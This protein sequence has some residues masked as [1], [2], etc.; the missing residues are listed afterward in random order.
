MN[1]YNE[2]MQT[3]RLAME[4]GI[5][6][7]LEGFK[8]FMEFIGNPQDSYS[9]VQIG[10]PNG[11]TS[12]SRYTAAILKQCGM[13]TGLYTSP[14]L[15]F[16][17]ERMEVDGAVSSDEMFADAIIS[18][19]DKAQE[20][21]QAGIIPFC[22][23]FELLTASGF[24][25]FEQEKCDWAVLEVGL[26]GMWDATSACT[27]KVAVVTGIDLEHTHILGNTVEEIAVQKAAI[28]KPG[29]FAILGPGTEET[30]QVFL[31]R[32]AEVG[33][34]YK[35]IEP[36]YQ[37]INYIGASYQIIN[38]TTAWAA[39][40]AA[41]SREIS[42]ETVQAAVD[43]LIIPG[44]FEILRDEP[45]LMIDATHNPQAAKY[46]VDAMEA[47]FT[48]ADDEN[49]VRK[50]NELDTLL[51]CILDDKD[52]EG[53]INTLAPLFRNIAVTQSHSTRAF[54]AE[55]LFELVKLYDGRTPRLF[56]NI[57]DALAEINANGETAM[58][59][60]SITLAGEAKATYLGK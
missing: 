12:T 48:F 27:P 10:G 23:E 6:A 59:T 36:P 14:E 44:R 46:L 2:A 8:A 17:P 42:L 21:V 7:K 60:G 35:I 56:K 51:L 11:K 4:N 3:V 50:V 29:S 22:T 47:R 37:D 9:C 26:G 58:I 25:M 45:L 20:A 33:A 38:I 52:A 34:D 1:R 54:P 53:I 13:K 40:E 5:E 39:A 28:I 18:T 41:L 43:G 24:R 30:R 16:Y 32:C 55:E 57:N 15:M 49:G 19:W 31:D